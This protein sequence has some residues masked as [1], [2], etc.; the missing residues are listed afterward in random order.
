MPVDITE[1]SIKVT[2]FKVDESKRYPK[3]SVPPDY[4]REHYGIIY[5]MSDGVYKVETFYH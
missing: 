3:V 4:F 1:M 2:H 5:R